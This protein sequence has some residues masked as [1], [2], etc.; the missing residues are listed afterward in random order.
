MSLRSLGIP[1]RGSPPGAEGCY[2]G[3]ASGGG[4]WPPRQPGSAVLGQ[5]LPRL[6]ATR[7]R[8]GTLL[9]RMGGALAGE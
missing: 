5:N 7:A 6:G 3:C 4:A 2:L 9:G 8:S 1:T